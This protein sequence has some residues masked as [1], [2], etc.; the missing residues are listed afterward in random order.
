MLTWILPMSTS[1]TPALTIMREV[2]A[3]VKS[4]VPAL[5][6]ETPEVMDS[7]ISM[8]FVRTT[9][10]IGATTLEPW[11]FCT[12]WLMGM[13]LFS[14]SAYFSRAFSYSWRACMYSA[15]VSRC[16]F[17][18]LFRGEQSLEE[19]LVVGLEVFLRFFETDLRG[20]ERVLGLGERLGLVEVGLDAGQRFAALHDVAVAMLDLDDLA[21]DRGLDLDLHFRL[22]G[23]DF[24]DLH[25]DVGDFGLAGLDRR[26]GRLLVLAVRLHRHRADNGDEQH[27]DRDDGDSAFPLRAHCVNLQVSEPL[28]V[29][30]TK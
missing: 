4:T 3:T 25:L 11:K 19:Q 30:M 17:A 27:E 7:P 5:N 6:D 10:L 28:F 26:L 12:D 16:C 29:G 8:F 1:L 24:R 13:P 9:P 20:G 14:T 22:D 15:S 2:S 18:V 21:G 23:A